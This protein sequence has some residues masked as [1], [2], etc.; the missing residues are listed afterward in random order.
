MHWIEPVPYKV[1]KM[2]MGQSKCTS[3]L[4]IIM[5][6]SIFGTY[7][8][9]EGLRSLYT[10]LDFRGFRVLREG[11]QFSTAVLALVDFHLAAQDHGVLDS[12]F[13]DFVLVRHV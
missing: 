9:R 12:H 8:V 6:L 1:F 3:S 5:T 2:E 13:V 7:L 11:P 10:T 4:L